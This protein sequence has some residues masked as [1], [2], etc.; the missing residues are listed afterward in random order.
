[1]NNLE[2]MAWYEYTKIDKQ[3]LIEETVKRDMLILSMAQSIIRK[4]KKMGIELIED[5][6]LQLPVQGS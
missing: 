2:P 3:K 4:Y 6:H 1:M 5:N